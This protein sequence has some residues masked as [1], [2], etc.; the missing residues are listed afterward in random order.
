MVLTK[1][2]LVI[3]SGSCQTR[4]WGG[5]DPACYIIMILHP[6]VTFILL[7]RSLVLQTLELGQ[8]KIEGQS[9]LN[10]KCLIKYHNATVAS[11]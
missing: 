8:L 7:H 3:L 1:Y 11:R 4:G 10:F 2:H 5:G 6:N 9:G